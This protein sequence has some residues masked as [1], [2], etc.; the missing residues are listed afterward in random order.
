[1]VAKLRCESHKKP[2]KK[3]LHFSVFLDIALAYRK[4]N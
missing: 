1:M 2:A 4:Q 3:L